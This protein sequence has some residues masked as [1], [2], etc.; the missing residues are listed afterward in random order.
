MQ[1]HHFWCRMYR[2]PRRSPDFHCW[3]WGPEQP[4]IKHTSTKFQGSDPLSI[5]AVMKVENLFISV[6]GVLFKNLKMSQIQIIFI[7]FIHVQKNKNLSWLAFNLLSSRFSNSW[8]SELFLS[9]SSA[10]DV[11]SHSLSLSPSPSI[12]FENLCTPN[13]YLWPVEWSQRTLREE[14]TAH[15]LN[16]QKGTVCDTCEEGFFV[17]F[18]LFIIYPSNNLIIYQWSA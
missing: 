3:S 5:T 2:K 16:K 10:A 8:E 12:L 4:R 1:W 15:E 13:A 18:S 7:Q 11:H 9:L 6:H 14:A 17:F